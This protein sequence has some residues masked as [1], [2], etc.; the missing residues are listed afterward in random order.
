MKVFEYVDHRGRGV[1]SEWSAGLQPRARAALDAKLDAVRNAGEPG[2][3]RHGEL[4]PNMFRGPVKYKGKF[5]PNTYKFTVNADG[6]SC[7]FRKLEATILQGASKKQNGAERKSLTT[8]LDDA[9]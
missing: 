2:D 7:L 4:P 8:R 5:Y 3:A 1:Y 6:A 9:S